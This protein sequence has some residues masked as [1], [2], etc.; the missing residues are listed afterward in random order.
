MGK[1]AA[2]DDATTQL[3]SAAGLGELLEQLS[4]VSGQRETRLSWFGPAASPAEDLGPAPSADL[5][6]YHELLG[7]GRARGGRFTLQPLVAT[8]MADVQRDAERDRHLRARLRS[9]FCA[10]ALVAE[11]EDTAIL[12]SLVGTGLWETSKVY[13]APCDAPELRPIDSS[14]TSWLYGELQEGPA[15]AFEGDEARPRDATRKRFLQLVRGAKLAPEVDPRALWKRC[16]WLVDV[17]FELGAKER[18][19]LLAQ[20]APFASYLRE[21]EQ[22]ALWPHLACYWLCA[23]YF[24]GNDE[25]LE[26]TMELATEHTHPAVVELRQVYALLRERPSAVFGR[27]SGEELAAQRRAVVDEAP[28][29]LLG[30][31]AKARRRG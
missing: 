2:G 30:P 11:G 13:R 8:A 6:A 12:V 15:P 20:A 18:P 25:E 9:I 7:G 16:D 3:F 27:W 31:G 26:E 1:R 14:L 21:K 28:S 22:I 4:I 17:F 24:C 10:T 23:H 5:C 19:E 29:R